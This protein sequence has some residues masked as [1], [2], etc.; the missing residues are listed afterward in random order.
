MNK[1]EILA[2]LRDKN[3]DFDVVYLDSVDSTNNFA[4][5][6]NSKNNKNN[7][8]VAAKKQT[9]GR[10]RYG[11][12]FDSPDGKGLYF[13]LKINTS[14]REPVF[15]PLIAAAAVSRAVDLSCGVRLNIKWPNDLLY[16]P[17]STSLTPPSER[18]AGG[19]K[20]LCGILT[21]AS[22]SYVIVGIGLN[23]NNNI[24][25][26]PEK[27]KNTAS[28]LKI[29]S[30]IEYSSRDFT[31]ILCGII[32]EFM[33]LMHVSGEELLEEY[34]KRLLLGLD[35]TFSQDG[36]IFKGKAAGINQNGNLIAKLETGEEI[37]IQSGEIGIL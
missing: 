33:R 5:E 15:F 20:K 1:Q 21:E 19:Y 26:F 30:G 9:D 16:L 2:L 8:L 14:G 37:I 32:N 28:S 17:P 12:G 31:D 27:I 22:A 11:R 7:L 25:D 23:I 35:I 13:T 6:Y 4:K 24:T 34:K 36:S 18:E 29:I 10:G 3:L